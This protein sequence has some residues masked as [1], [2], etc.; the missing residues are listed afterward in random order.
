VGVPDASRIELA[1]W[2]FRRRTRFVVV[3]PSM[4]PT[5]QAGQVVLIEPGR[6]MLGDVVVALHPRR[7]GLKIIKR[8]VEGTAADGWMLLSDNAAEPNSEDGRTFGRVGDGAIV[9]RV[10]CVV[11]R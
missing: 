8:L 6:H 5:L 11:R 1:R 7:T 9:G 2:V 4:E 3:G 10:T